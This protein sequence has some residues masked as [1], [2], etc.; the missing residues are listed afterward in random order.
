MPCNG[1]ST[2]G[3]RDSIGHC[4]RFEINHL[5]PVGIAQIWTTS[6]SVRDFSFSKGILGLGVR[7]FWFL[8]EICWLQRFIRRDL[9]LGAGFD[10][11]SLTMWPAWNHQYVCMPQHK[12]QY[13]LLLR[14]FVTKQLFISLSDT[15]DDKS[16]Q[17][18]VTEAPTRS[19][20]ST[21]STFRRTLWTI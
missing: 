15:G 6:I 14:I 8:I 9:P 18:T 2:D 4:K 19:T 16:T 20:L 17:R 11:S 1:Q 3:F 12:W 21:Q 13:E 5:H 10:L 7:D